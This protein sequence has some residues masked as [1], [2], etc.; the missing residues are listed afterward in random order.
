MYCTDVCCYH[1]LRY[2]ALGEEKKNLELAWLSEVT[3]RRRAG[4]R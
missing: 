2:C 1:I 3:G 4:A